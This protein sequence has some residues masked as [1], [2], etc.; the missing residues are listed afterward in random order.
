MKRFF[1]GMLLAVSLLGIVGC[2]EYDP[3]STERQ[4]LLEQCL[5]EPTLPICRDNPGNTE[6]DDPPSM[7]EDD[8]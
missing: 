1:V 6:P 8:F 4:D 5:N 3:N 7:D 2:T